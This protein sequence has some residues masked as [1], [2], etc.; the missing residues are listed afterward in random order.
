MN[1]RSDQPA[2]DI[3]EQ[4][5]SIC[6]EFRRQLR[7]GSVC[8]I[9]D[10]I[11]RVED[12]AQGNLF[13]QLLSA[14]VTARHR[15]NDHPTSSDYIDRFPVFASQVRQV[16]LEP[17]LSSIDGSDDAPAFE[18]TLITE[19]PVGD[20]LGDYELLSER[21]RGAF[22]IVYEAR[23]VRRDDRVALKTLRFEE[24]PDADRLHRF[25]QEFRRLA[26]TN[27]PHLVGMQTLE[28]DENKQQ[29]FFTMELVDGTDFLSYVRPDGELDEKRL[30]HVLPQLVNGISG[31]HAQHIVHRDLKPSNVMVDD[32][33]R[34]VV[35]DFGLV[36]ELQ[37]RLDQSVSMCSG[38]FSGT[39][40]YAAPEQLS[41]RRP[42]AADWY[43]LGV[44]IYEALTGD[45]PFYGSIA[46]LIVMKKTLD[47]PR[48]SKRDDLPT[49][50][51]SLVD[52]LLSRDPHDR[53]DETQIASSLSASAG[54]SITDSDDQGTRRGTDSTE[55][56]L[57]GRETQLAQLEAIRQE[58]MDSDKPVVV[59]V[60]G[61]SG[62]GKTALIDQFLEPL[63]QGPQTLVLSGKCYDRES[64]PYKA[65]DGLIDALVGY[66]RSLNDE[67]VG[68]L[69]PE[70]T[71]ML[72]QLFPVTRRVAGIA[73]LDLT[74]VKRLD[75]K[76]VRFRAFGALKEL[77]LRIT[78]ETSLVMFIDDLQWGDADSADMLAR[79]LSPP[80]SPA[81]LVIGSFRSDEVDNSAFL[82]QWGRF[83]IQAV[84]HSEA[85]D[86]SV[87][88]EMSDFRVTVGPF[89]VEECEQLV[90]ARVGE[91]SLSIRASSAE[92]HQSTAGNPYLI[93]QITEG[94]NPETGILNPLPLDEV[95]ESRLNRLPTD[96]RRL[97]EV[98][99]VSGH[100]IAQHEAVEV[101][102]AGFSVLNRMRNERLV[103]LIGAAPS[104]QV[105][106][107]HDK[108]REKVL[109]HIDEPRRR[110]LHR[111]IGETIE[112]LD[113]VQ[114]GDLIRS[115]EADSDSHPAAAETPARVHD[116]ALHFVA[117]GNETKGLAYSLLAAEFAKQQ[118]ALELAVSNY[119]RAQRFA[120]SRSS[121]VQYRVMIGLGSTQLLAGHYKEAQAC[122]E[123][124]IELAGS[125]YERLSAEA[126][127]A[128]IAYKTGSLKDS[129]SFSEQLLSRLG[130][131]VPQ[132]S[133]GLIFA[134]LAIQ[135]RRA[136]GTL[137]PG[138]QIDASTDWRRSIAIRIFHILVYPCYV[139]DPMRALWASYAGYI[140]SIRCGNPSL[141]CLMSGVAGN[142]VAFSLCHRPSAMRYL[143]Q[144][145]Q[146]AKEQND[147]VLQ[148]QSIYMRAAASVC[149]GRF[150]ESESAVR[151]AI[152]LYLAIGDVWRLTYSQYLLATVTAR[153]GDLGESVKAA[154][155]S[156]LTATQFGQS[157]AAQIVIEPWAMA[158]DGNLPL[159]QLRQRFQ[160][161]PDDLWS[162]STLHVAESAWH[163]HHS[164]FE[165]S[166]EAAEKATRA[167]E[168]LWPIAN[169]P[170]PIPNPVPCLAIINHAH[171]LRALA[172]SIRDSDPSR[173]QSLSKWALRKAKR[174]VRVQ[175]IVKLDHSYA[176]R[177]LAIAYHGVDKTTKAYKYAIKSLQVAEQH[178]AKHQYAKTLLVVG[179]L[180]EKLG[181]PDARQ[182]IE[183]AE[184][185][186]AEFDG[187]IEKA[188]LKAMEYLGL[189]KEAAIS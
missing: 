91:D 78:Q 51:T 147:I 170:W 13:Q 177:E 86:S 75:A 21:G 25:R 97:L 92:I 119:R 165:T 58:W 37:E 55:L 181:K 43:A 28:F 137:V 27:H 141:Q 41:G 104:T 74:L 48:L 155:H 118:Y 113:E 49:D 169:T 40:R 112:R 81:V 79:M 14:E 167:L 9:E 130:V 172:E 183:E 35:L 77:L 160:P 85:S 159:E 38:Q 53:P 6:H 98:I 146:L 152:D 111:S 44:M 102:G 57:I 163:R 107:Y 124:A 180:G 47:A 56:T 151:R 174:A 162:T 103:R 142:S 189:D 154:S 129:I 153:L 63:R 22:G 94:L 72:A 109:E 105:D 179:Q 18:P 3:F 143:D 4:I 70:D 96:A 139:R 134:I 12:S 138:R 175:R 168:E 127:L 122:L 59:F 69:L 108:I 173:S 23:H 164:R 117:S 99:A 120:V 187:Q 83:R 114:I 93:D 135:L 184:K 10:Y 71:D 82:K 32:Q 45:A 95:I 1:Q 125:D 185:Q 54:S 158:T 84:A 19:I 67:E 50:L 140:L 186:L 126:P 171:A 101:A 80:N 52:Q 182:L 64:V 128:E 42:A 116:L 15:R 65:I 16:F 121:S 131:H 157:R 90:L 68:R 31:L 89:S 20:R 29:W 145:A 88:A 115:I 5:Q 73:K 66:L 144:A 17:S 36:A 46:D 33:S 34:V 8:R 148:A 136:T 100:A 133:F 150:R 39:I 123:S 176:L 161:V 62:E 26:D 156:F 76:Q 110:H 60:S 132:S 61:K 106:T 11:K 166:L 7:K 30:R 2:D 87:D 149:L 24:E 188:N 178:G